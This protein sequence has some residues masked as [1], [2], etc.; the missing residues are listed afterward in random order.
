MYLKKDG[1]MAKLFGTDG[2]RGVANTGLKPELAFR[3]G[4]CG[5]AILSRQKSG[6]RV[7]VGRD[8]RIS[9]DMLEAAL[10]AGI[11][12]VGGEVIKVGVLPTPAVAWLTRELEADAGVMISASHNP[13]ED[14]GIKFFSHSGHK[15]PDQLEEEIEELLNKSEDNLPRPTGVGLGRVKELKEISDRYVNYVCST[16]NKS[17]S[18]M[19]VVLDCANGAAYQVAG[20]IFLRLGAE[21]F[22]LNNTPDGTNINL[23][24]GSTNPETL[25]AEVLAKKAHVGLAFDGDSDRVIA[26]DEKGQIVNGDAIMTILALEWHKQGKL[27]G[28]QLV[29]TVMSNYGLHK[30]LK[31][32]G[33]KV[34]QTKVG[35]R[36]V[37]EEMLKRGAVLGGEQSGH[38]ILLDYNTTGDGLITGVQLLQVMVNTGKSLSEL[39]SV[40]PHLPQLLVN[41]TVR[42]KD[43]AMENPKLLEAVETVQEKLAGRGRV[44]VRPSGTE[45]IIRLMLEGPDE[46][47][48]NSLMEILKKAV[49]EGE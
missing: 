46:E 20:E 45:P 22:L 35:D 34:R 29:V 5:A 11:C 12:S 25:Q 14:N 47:E 44:L 43:A 15:L 39:A 21:V 16:V 40:M 13:V 26:V 19:R 17:L 6:V 31:G 38:I 27:P 36:Y 2:V 7:V 23:K 18:G 4:R 3:L 8:T 24:C 30:T 33:L 10:I 28:D 37:L 32:A 42:N 1:I 48:L 41:V 49:V 9:G